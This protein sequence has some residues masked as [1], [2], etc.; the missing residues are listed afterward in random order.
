MTTISLSFTDFWQGHDPLNNILTNAV[1]YVFNCDIHITTPERADICFV[2]IYGNSYKKVLSKYAKKSILWLG[3]NVRPNTLFDGFSIS[4][5]FHSYSNKN[6]RLP[7]WLSEIDWFGTGLGVIHINDVHSRLVKPSTDLFSRSQKEFCIT[8]FNNPEGTR[9]DLF[10]ILNSI[11]PVTGYGRPFGNWFPTYENYRD[12]LSKLGNYI[13]NLCPEN[14][15]YP[16]Y[17]TEKCF[18][19]KVAG[20]IPIYFADT[21]V[22][23]DF[24][25]HSFVNAY[26]FI[27]ND[28]F[29][30]YILCLL[31][32][33]SQM[34][35][36]YS[37]PLLHQQPCLDPFYHFI[38]FS[39]SSIIASL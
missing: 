25:P 23:Y 30:E 2:T 39:V 4:F 24:N 10:K 29:R 19:A 38:R 28:Q 5:D 1:R 22:K 18:H 11:Q 17:Y 3:E 33:D 36:L 6:F 12:K 20:C 31:E 14:S 34:S 26:D 37:Q 9:L 15:L 35:S 27:S 16:G 21:Y 13:F 32:S 8:V 7:L